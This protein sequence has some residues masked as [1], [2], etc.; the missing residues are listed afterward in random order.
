MLVSKHIYLYQ[1]QQKRFFIFSSKSSNNSH[2]K[3]GKCN[4]L[5]SDSL[6]IL[7]SSQ[8]HQKLV[9]TRQAKYKLSSKSEWSYWNSDLE[10]V[11]II[12]LHLFFF[13][14]FPFLFFQSKEM[15]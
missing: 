5:S 9:Q 15:H 12:L 2:L 11:T 13:F 14:F 10:E 3:Y 8:D 6:A 4:F 1:Q 7:K